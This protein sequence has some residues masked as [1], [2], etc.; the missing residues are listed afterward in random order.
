MPAAALALLLSS[1]TCSDKPKYP[2]ESYE[3]DPLQTRIYTLGNG[4]KVYLSVNRD[5]P[6]VQANIAVRAGSKYDPAETTG[7]AHYLEHMLFKGNSEI[8]SLDWESEKV[9]LQKISDLY[10]E[11][12]KTS[13]PERKKAIYFRIDSISQLAAGYVVAN[14]YDKMV[15]SLGAKGT[16][17]YTSNERTVYINDL[18]ANE[19]EKWLMLESSRFRELTLRLF[20]TELEAVYEE[21]NRSQDNDY[22][23]Q[24]YGIFELLFPKHQYGTQT[25]IGEGEHLK[26]PSMVNI[27]DYFNK[28]YV[29]N[30]MAVIIAGD[31]DYDKT[32]ALVD[33]Y[34]GN[35]K[36]REIPAYTAPVE[37]AITE[38]RTM[39]VFGP[40]AERLSLAYRLE[41]SDTRDAYMLKL[42]DGILTNGKAG[43]IDINLIQKQEVLEAYSYPL[44][45]KDYSVLYLAATPKSG[46][47]LDQAKDLLLQ[48]I[49]KLRKGEFEDWLP[50]A[51]VKDFKLNETRNTENNG[52]RAYMLT[53]AF[54]LEQ[55]WGEVIRQNDSLAKF[56]K[57]EIVAFANEKFGEN[58]AV[59]FKKTGIDTS[60]H[61]VDKP[62]ITPVEINRD[63]Q[64]VF[65]IR[66]DSM[67]DVRLKAEFLD[68]E[69]DISHGK[70]KE[71]IAYY[72]IK[73]EVNE[74]FT[75]N[76][77]LEMGAYHDLEMALAVDYLPFLG[78]SAYS[79]E[80]LSKEFFKIG[81]EYDVYTSGE[82]IYVTLSGLQESFEEGL[83]LFESLL[84]D[85]QPD[86][87]AL[88]KLV[89]NKLKER[90]D[91]KK[92]KAYIHQYAMSSY[93]KYGSDNP[94]KHILKEG[95]MKAISAGKLTEKIHLLTSYPHLVFYYGPDDG[96]KTA[97]VLKSVHKTPAELLTY[98][99]EKLFPELENAEDIVYFV[100]FD[101]VQTE[102]LMVSK[103]KSFSKE[104]LPYSNIFNEYFGSGL[105]SIIFQEI[106]ESKALAY[107][108]YC[109]YTTPP[110][111]DRSHY[112]QAYIGTQ[113]NKLGQATDAIKE[114]L[115]NMP[116]AEGQFNDS[117]LAALKKIET[118]RITRSGIFW[119]YFSAKKLGL[120]ED[121]RKF[122][123]SVIEK[124]SMADLKKFFDEYIKGR[125][126]TYCVIGK[127]SEVD[128][129]ALK[130]LGRVQELTLPEVFGY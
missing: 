42:I 98:P 40:N 68:Y 97:E 118:D 77:I 63:T 101:M 96:K 20:H 69:K 16:N 30:N 107:A 79:A 123:Y 108:A 48:Q 50:S 116:E 109:N 2:Y 65:A 38:V 15:S 75:L 111:K 85:A 113:T 49:D 129:D 114:L 106:R 90:D 28:Y 59:V 25:T 29:P 66:F 93:A 92:D 22:R 37:D 1:C 44:T 17:A 83:K 112:L 53:D 5:E 32:I 105:S 45:L 19:L 88:A 36:P 91:Q 11:H 78:T 67:P 87:S 47:S 89:E 23:K 6:R 104:I 72:S 33:K 12:R 86:T 43:L 21:F 122:Q 71:G 125:K 52:F 76:Y 99:E 60:I 84:S 56:T 41:G 34:F 80:E 9:L 119:N 24:Y 8:G 121:V 64:S 58:Y 13:D 14:E 82:Y 70:L 74:L 35:W 46:Q 57:E 4:M 81:V 127:R 55:N 10:E 100:D 117:K 103:S 51:V 31:V 39:D 120:D 126:Y 94:Y 115:N 26:N 61:K 18:P 102:M 3:N 54:I 62:A 7:L 73:N 27:H 128:F 124:M 95:E 110:E 130:K